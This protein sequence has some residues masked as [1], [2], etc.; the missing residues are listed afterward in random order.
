MSFLFVLHPTKLWTKYFHTSCL[1]YSKVLNLIKLW[2]IHI[3]SKLYWSSQLYLFCV[4]S[5]KNPPTNKYCE[6]C[7]NAPLTCFG[8]METFLLSIGS[9]QQ[10]QLWAC[11][12]ISI[13]RPR[14]W[15]VSLG[16]GL[17]FLIPSAF[18]W[19]REWYSER[20][21]G[22]SRHG[23]GICKLAPSLVLASTWSIIKN[24]FK[25]STGYRGSSPR[26][27]WSLSQWPTMTAK[28][29]DIWCV[30][31]RNH[32]RIFIPFHICFPPGFT[33]T[34]ARRATQQKR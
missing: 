32:G 9:L 26:H 6:G 19:S 29:I 13:V 23:H 16:R 14:S 4:K 30:F 31:F 8:C 34:L 3:Q 10:V 18:L 2:W 25:T 22:G 1:Q 24:R 33:C 7:L 11:F 20:P 15:A 21:I 12:Q 27:R 17:N 28:R 5:K